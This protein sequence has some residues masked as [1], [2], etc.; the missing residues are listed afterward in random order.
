[1]TLVF[2]VRRT[3]FDK[4]RVETVHANTAMVNG[5]A[6]H[7]HRGLRPSQQ[8]VS[9]VAEL[10]ETRCIIPGIQPISSK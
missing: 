9:S 4:V 1:M 10:M 6:T 2:G 5:P 3:Y 7:L 8:T